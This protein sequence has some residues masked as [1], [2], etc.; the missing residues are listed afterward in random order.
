MPLQRRRS[1]PPG[2]SSPHLWRH[3]AELQSAPMTAIS[4]AAAGSFAGQ[5]M[6]VVQGAPLWVYLLAALAPWLPILALE[7]IWT[8]RH[9]RWVAVFCLLIVS[10]GAYL[11][12]HAAQVI[13]DVVL[14]RPGN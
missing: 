5:I 10:Q 13:Q 9:Y 7:I 14:G 3:L 1:H 6:A 8:Y 12:E 4:I 2:M 11:L